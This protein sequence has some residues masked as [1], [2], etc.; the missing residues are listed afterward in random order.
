MGTDDTTH[1]EGR[2]DAPT[3]IGW[4][5]DAVGK[6]ALGRRKRPVDPL[7]ALMHSARL[8]RWVET[9][10]VLLGYTVVAGVLYQTPLVSHASSLAAGLGLPDNNAYVWMLAWPAYA[11]AHGLGLFHPNIV[12]VP[13]GYNLARATPMFTFGVPLA[14]LTALAGPIVTYNVVM[15]AVPV[16]NGSSAY[17]LCRRLGA[18]PSQA[19]MGG[20]VFATSGVVSFSELGAPSTG[21][22]AFIALAV[23]LTLNLLDGRRPRRRTAVWLG[24]DLVAQLYCS[25]ELLTTFLL[26]GIFAL[27]VTWL[28]DSR[29]RGKIRRVLPSLA[30]AGA[31]LVIGGLPYVLAFA[32]DG[33][34]GLSHANPNLYP[35]DLLGFVVPSPLFRFGRSYFSSLAATFTGEAPEAYIGIGLLV[36]TVWYLAERWRTQVGARILGMVMVV[37]VVCSL[38]THLTIAGHTTIPM[39]WDLVLHVPLLHYALPSR[40]SIFIALGV[41]VTTAMWLK[42]KPSLPRWGIALGSCALLVPNPAVP[43]SISFH[44]PRFFTSGAAAHEFTN[45]DRV[46]VLPFAGPDDEAQA[47]SGFAFSLAG[48]YLGQYPNSYGQYIAATYLIQ[49]SSPP[50]APSRVAELVHAKHVDVVVVDES[51]PGPWH[52][53]FSGLGV[54]PV[55]REGVLIYRINGPG[56]VQ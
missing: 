43:W 3:P 40:L 13:E 4:S 31:I 16:L 52:Q 36:I 46:M 28:L 11:I 14:P 51:A 45:R 22:G 23:L 19:A 41:S 2:Q 18:G 56:G 34:T 50:G 8:D 54:Q 49:R 38:G 32:F 37:L 12:F 7:G 15:L 53:L 33:G 21:C 44:T 17:A 9:L 5:D 10:A 35:N 1:P 48:G 27:M 42:R 47:E 24:V 6:V 55:S 25:A 26:F 39:P 30:G 20:F 29:R